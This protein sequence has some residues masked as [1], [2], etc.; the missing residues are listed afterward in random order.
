MQNSK[1]NANIPFTLS[2][3]LFHA[4]TKKHVRVS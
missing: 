4:L 2:R 1:Y 3:I